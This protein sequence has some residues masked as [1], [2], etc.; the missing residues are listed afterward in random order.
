MACAACVLSG[1]SIMHDSE[2]P[3]EQID[4]PAVGIK[5]CALRESVY[6][7]IDCC[8]HNYIFYIHMHIHMYVNMWVH[9]QESERFQ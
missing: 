1:M 8:I 2:N 9:A 5:R 3:L 6:R 4:S 7:T